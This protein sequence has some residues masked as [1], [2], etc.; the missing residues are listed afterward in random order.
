MESKI[1]KFNYICSIP[2]FSLR[3][4]KTG[5]KIMSSTF[6]IGSEER[7]EWSIWV[8]PNGNKEKSK[9]YVSVYLALLKPDKAKIKHRFSILN[10]MGEEKNILIV[11]NVIDLDKENGRGFPKFVKRDFLL[12]ESNG[13]LVNDKLTILC[14]GEIVELKSENRENSISY[15]VFYTNRTDV[16]HLKYI[17]TVENFS[18]RPEKTGEKII[19]P[20]FVVGSEERSEW[21]LHICPNG[22]DKYSKEYISVYL[23]LLKPDKAKA[24]YR[25]SILNDKKE[26]KHVKFVTESEDFVKDIGLGFSQFVKKVFLLDRSNSLLFNDKLTIVCEAE[27]IKL[28]S[29]NPG[30]IKSYD[31]LYTSQTDVNNFKYEYTIQNFSLRPEKTGEKIISPTFVVGS[32]E[33]SEWH[34]WVYPNGDEEESK[35]YVSVYLALLKPDKAKIKFGFSI[36]NDNEKKN[37]TRIAYNIIDQNK[38]YGWGFTKYVKK[39][40]LLDKSNGLLVNDKLTILCE[41]EIFELISENHEISIPYDV[42]YTSQTNVNNFK[43]EYTIQNFSLRPEKTG[44]KIISPTFVVGSEERSE[45]CLH[46]CP[47]GQDEDSK[48]YIS[49]YLTLLKPDKAKAKYRFS[50]LNDNK[51]EKNVKFVTESKDFVKDIGLGF[52]QFV[53]K[54]F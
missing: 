42:L 54:V 41:T 6:V 29:E 49:V 46:I 26:E 44:E 53:K 24:K 39:N 17:Y 15:D 9:E 25:F 10:D 40:F 47:N 20:T 45:W 18:L 11:K 4:E 14:E 5:E 7:S 31:V 33:R 35:E 37:N 1:N 28:E 19:S 51:E 32:E 48:E 30:N 13:L 34:L 43:Y 3:P 23:T 22:Q 12:D 36:L 50:I 21:C 38:E 52:S 8:Y 27:I 2:N 16:N